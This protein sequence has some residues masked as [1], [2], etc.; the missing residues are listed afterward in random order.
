LRSGGTGGANT[1]KNG[2]AFEKKTSLRD[3]LVKAGMTVSADGHVFRDSS[4]PVGVLVG[5]RKLEKWLASVYDAN[6]SEV[7]ISLRKSG[8]K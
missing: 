3:S 7:L 1:N 2:L 6:M 4:E 8:K 5:Q